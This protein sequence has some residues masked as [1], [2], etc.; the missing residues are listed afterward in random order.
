MQTLENQQFEHAY[1][2]SGLASC[3]SF[4]LFTVDAFKYG[5]EYFPV[6]VGVEPFNG[7]PAS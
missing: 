5:A 4:A 1:P 3:R 7:S 2:A 6:D